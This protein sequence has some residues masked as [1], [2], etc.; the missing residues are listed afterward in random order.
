MARDIPAS[1]CEPGPLTGVTTYAPFRTSRWTRRKE[2][3]PGGDVSA[4]VVMART[5]GRSTGVAP[6]IVRSAGRTKA[7]KLTS[8]LTGL[9]GRPKT[10]VESGPM[11]PKPCGIPGCI[12]TLSNRTVPSRE[13]TSFTTSYAPTLTPPLVT[14]T[15]ARTSWSSSV[16]A[17]WCGS[18]GTM[19]TR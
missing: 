16:A 18:S 11:V 2:R 6:S 15:S 4:S 10:G 14:S 12:A 3:L 5:R 8:A 17:S 13:S 1:R 19:P 9:P 7:S